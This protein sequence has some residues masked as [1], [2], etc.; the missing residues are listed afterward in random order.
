MLTDDKAQAGENYSLDDNV[1]TRD[2]RRALIWLIVLSVMSVGFLVALGLQHVSAPEK[3]HGPPDGTTAG[4]VLEFEDKQHSVQQPVGALELPGMIGKDQSSRAKS[5]TAGNTPWT[6]EETAKLGAASG[7][8]DA[9]GAAGGT[10]GTQPAQ[11]NKPSESAP[12]PA[13][14]H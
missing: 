11:T 13:P 10:E 12:A 6:P 2:Q 1:N 7:N 14:A 4:N 3:P 9:H 8:A 5:L